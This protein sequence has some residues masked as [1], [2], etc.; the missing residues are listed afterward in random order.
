MLRFFFVVTFSTATNRFSKPLLNNTMDKKLGTSDSRRN[1]IGKLAKVAAFSSLAP[2]IVSAKEQTR[3]THIL[4][5]ERYSFNDQLQIALIGAGG[6][7]NADAG[8]AIT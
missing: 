4:Q 6:M 8:T 5:R 1:F 7:G 3:I 2:Y